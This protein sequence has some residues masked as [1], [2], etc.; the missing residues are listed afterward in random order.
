MSTPEQVKQEH[1][2]GLFKELGVTVGATL[3]TIQRT[4]GVN[5]ANAMRLM[6]LFY[7]VR[8]AVLSESDARVRALVENI[9]REVAELPDRTSP[10]D[11]PE[12]ML[13]TAAELSAIVAAALGLKEA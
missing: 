13:V 4:S 8:S 10:D 3:Q 2:A 11:W 9:V 1:I 7:A 6:A 5:T 12:A